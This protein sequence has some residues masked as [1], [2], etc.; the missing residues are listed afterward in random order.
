LPAAIGEPAFEDLTGRAR[1]RD[2]ALRLFAE[3][4]VEGTTVRSI[5]RAAGVRP[6]TPMCWRS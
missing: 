6:A 1:I 4:G 5:A 3:G 2:A